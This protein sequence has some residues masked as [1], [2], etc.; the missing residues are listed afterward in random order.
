MIKNA[1]KSVNTQILLH[2]ILNRHGLIK[3]AYKI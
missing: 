1:F 2:T 3:I